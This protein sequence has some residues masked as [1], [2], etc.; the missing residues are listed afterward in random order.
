MARG[1]L[2]G[3]K[4]RV[5]KRMDRGYLKEEVPERGTSRCKGPEAGIFD[6]FEEQ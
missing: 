3:N 4:R 2:S 1:H 5:K 6:M